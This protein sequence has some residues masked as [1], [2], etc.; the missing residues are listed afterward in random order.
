LLVREDARLPLVAMSAVFK[1]GLLAETPENNGLTKLFSRVILKGTKSRTAE[2]I[3]DQIEA[4]GGTIG[5]DA[6]NNSFTVAAK[7]MKPDLK[8]GLDIFADVLLNP[9]APEKAVA[10]EKEIQLAG[11]KEEDEE[12]TN[13]ARNLMRAN[14]FPGHPYGLRGTG[15]PETVAKLTQADLLDF[16]KQYVVGKNCVIAIF[17]DVKATEIKKLVEAELGKMPA[18]TPAL[19]EV[20]PAAPL[21][22]SLSVAEQKKK[23]Q[24][25]LMVGYRGTDMFDPDGYAL[26][27]ID[28]ASSDLGSRFFVRIREKMGLAY[29]V[30]SSQTMGLV[31]GPFIFYL[32]TS[33]EKVDAVRVEL[34]DEIDKLSREGLTAEELAR[35]KEKFIG[36]QE[37]RNQSEDAFAYASA[38]DELYG[39]GYAHYRELKE[40][41]NAVTLDDI[42]RVAAKFFHEQPNV[43]ATV[44]PAE[45]KTN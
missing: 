37:I 11:I 6:G 26:Q 28:E 18:G 35:A 10:R 42:K 19:V 41:V 29:F 20:K 32:G 40:K 8:T 3:A 1:A 22:R 38:L 45:N 43:I 23:E 4:V 13:V 15:T 36:Q 9:I 25:I 39:L 12:V 34:L 30:G 31:P 21:E 2:Q 24:A 44:R 5:S 27:L 14:L 17:G 33:P 7:V 16:H